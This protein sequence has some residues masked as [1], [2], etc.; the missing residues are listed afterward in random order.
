[1]T[2]AVA[3]TNVDIV[4]GADARGDRRCSTAARRRDEILEKT[5]AVLG[6][7]RRDARPSARARSAC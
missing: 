4:F 1:M 5:G 7:R 3:F 6:V 2:T